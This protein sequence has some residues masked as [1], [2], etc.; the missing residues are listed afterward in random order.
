MQWSKPSQRAH[1]LDLARAARADY[2]GL[3]DGRD[4]V[5]AIDVWLRPP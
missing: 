1:A 5:A 2:G 4:A 3:P